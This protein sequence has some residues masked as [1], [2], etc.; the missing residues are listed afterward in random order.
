MKGPLALFV[1]LPLHIR[2]L[3][4]VEVMNVAYVCTYMKNRGI[5]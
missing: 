2:K 1:F 3:G 5:S 4:G